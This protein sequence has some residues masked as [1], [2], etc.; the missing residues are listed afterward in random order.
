MTTPIQTKAQELRNRGLAVPLV[1]IELPVNPADPNGGKFVALPLLFMTIYQAPGAAHAYVVQGAILAQYL[2]AGGPLGALGYP[3]TDELDWY[4]PSAKYT[5]F[6][7]GVV[8]WA[9]DAGAHTTDILGFHLA[10]VQ[11]RLKA[12][13]QLPLE[14][15]KTKILRAEN[16]TPGMEWC[17][18]TL[19]Y[20]F[21]TA[22]MDS[23][24]TGKFYHVD[25]LLDYGSYG[26][27]TVYGAAKNP[28]Q[29]T[30]VLPEMRDLRDVH[31]ERGMQ[32]KVTLWPDLQ[33]GRALDILPGDI[34]LFDRTLTGGA[35]HIQLV[36]SW[37]PAERVLVVLDGNG[38]SFVLRSVLE[39]QYGT[40]LKAGVHYAVASEQPEG[41]YRISKAQK[42]RWLNQFHKM[43]VLWPISSSGYVGVT[44]HKL[45]ADGQS[46]PENDT[47][48]NPHARVFAII[49][50]SL[51]DFEHHR[52]QTD[53]VTPVPRPRL[54]PR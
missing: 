25:P 29:I 11:Y 3:E 2:L 48:N 27:L 40:N 1:L 30:R 51:M 42:V 15:S 20:A 16:F 18:A 49:R 34:V 38:K 13:L 46:N 37:H 21:K 31:K 14:V 43:D 24:H 7:K 47:S 44:C 23:F 36:M 45:T 5:M 28:T 10:S 12:L 22:G 41:A 17:G 6:V 53:S 52:Y 35:D 32:R 19:A 4:D 8:H 33:S 50:P 54:R 26:S 39:K 9:P